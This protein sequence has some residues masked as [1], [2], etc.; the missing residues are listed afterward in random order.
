MSSKITI[1]KAKPGDKEAIWTIIEPVVKG[2]DTYVFDPNS[3][4]EKML[5]YWLSQKKHVYVAETDDQLCGT[6]I[7][8]D[9][10]P[11]LGSHIANGSYMVHPNFRGRG[12]G[13]LLGS[14]SIEEAKRLSY[15][16]I[17]FNIVVKSNETAVSLWKQLGFKVIGE[18][19]EAFQ[20]KKLGLTDALIMYRK[21]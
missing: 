17:Q 20:H 1:R 10:Q 14:H 4:K 16:A 9:N 8:T 18:V 7:L 11:D 13:K 12:I 2:G 21:L 15:K 3:P 6:Y 19:P 5:D